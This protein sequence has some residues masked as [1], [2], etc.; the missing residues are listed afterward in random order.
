VAAVLIFRIGE[1]RSAEWLIDGRVVG[2]ADGDTITVLDARKKQHKVRFAGSDALER[3][4]PM[5]GGQGEPCQTSLDK[6]VEA[7]CYKVHRY[8]RSVWRVNQGIEMLA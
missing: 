3:V 7:R 6:R 5:A 8:Q 4:S 1:V 2:V